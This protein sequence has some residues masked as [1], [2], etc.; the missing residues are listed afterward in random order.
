[1]FQIKE[2]YAVDNFAAFGITVCSRNLLLSLFTLA[3]VYYFRYHSNLELLYSVSSFPS[4]YI[5]LCI[6]QTVK[7]PILTSFNLSKA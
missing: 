3:M 1:M 2:T 6:N 7:R 5:A 4:Y